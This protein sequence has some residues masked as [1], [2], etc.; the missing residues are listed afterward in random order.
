MDQSAATEA[1]EPDPLVYVY[2][3]Q[4]GDTLAGVA[5]KFNCSQAAFRRIN[6]LWPNDNI[7]TRKFLLLPVDT[8]GVRGYKLAGPGTT[9][10]SLTDDDGR[11]LPLTE[12]PPYQDWIIPGGSSKAPTLPAPKAERKVSPDFPDHSSWDHDSWVRID[13]FPSPVEVA[14]PPRRHLGFFPPA[15][16]KSATRTHE[17]SVSAKSDSPP[18]TSPGRERDTLFPSAPTSSRHIQQSSAFPS[19]RS[20]ISYSH[21]SA[22]GAAAH[23]VSTLRGPGGVGTLGREAKGP[24]P[25]PDKLNEILAPHLPSMAPPASAL[26]H[27]SVASL[28]VSGNHAPRASFE[29]V[30]S[31]GS[32]EALGGKVERWARKMAAG[33]K[34]PAS[35]QGDLIEL[36]E[37]WDAGGNYGVNGDNIAESEE[38]TDRGRARKGVTGDRASQKSAEDGG[39]MD[40]QMLAERFGVPT[41]GRVFKQRH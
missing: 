37:G 7:Q 33:K 9:S 31:A 14:R 39:H 2:Q 40:E 19:P 1:E 36:V 35:T 3:V 34:A 17:S 21:T 11:A 10:D 32:L 24:G 15:R 6:R 12:D 27:A 29:S 20:S 30:G 41:G 5:I 38:L 23:F 8:C 18:A 22:A 4:P 26:P 13:G 28:Q 16:R 25:A